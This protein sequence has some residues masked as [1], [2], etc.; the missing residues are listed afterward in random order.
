MITSKYHYQTSLFTYE[1]QSVFVALY[2]DGRSGSPAGCAGLS[3]LKSLL[4]PSTCPTSSGPFTLSCAPD[5][6]L[7]SLSV[8][9]CYKISA[10]TNL[11]AT[12]AYNSHGA[13]GLRGYQGL[14]RPLS[15]ADYPLLSA[16][17]SKK[18]ASC[19]GQCVQ[20]PHGAPAA[21]LLHL[22]GLRGSGVSSAHHDPLSSALASPYGLYGCG[23]PVTPQLSSLVRQHAKLANGGGA[24]ATAA[25]SA[26]LP[27]TQTESLLRQ[28]ASWHPAINHCL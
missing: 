18:T 15:V 20:G 13:D 21:C 5:S 7:H 10:P 22:Q 11:L 17:H 6:P 8:P 9:L 28:A 12:R 23:L 4:P 2:A 3:S 25:A 1:S 24:V 26:T 19:R 14:L 16:L 27:A